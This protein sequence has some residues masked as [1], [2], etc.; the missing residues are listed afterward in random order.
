VPVLFAGA[1]KIDLIVSSFTNMQFTRVNEYVMVC[2][3]ECVQG[4]EIKVVNNS[5]PTSV[6]RAGESGD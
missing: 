4:L 3:L 1:Y 5:W 6:H 2:L